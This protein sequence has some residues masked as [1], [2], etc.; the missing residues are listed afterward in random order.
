MGQTIVIV[1]DLAIATELL[2][3]RS[4]IHSSRPTMEFASELLV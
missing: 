4:A 1:N 3:K 2:T